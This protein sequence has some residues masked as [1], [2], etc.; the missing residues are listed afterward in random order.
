LS[1]G[2]ETVL[3]LL[4]AVGALILYILAAPFVLTWKLT[5][6]VTLKIVDGILWFVRGWE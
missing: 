1:F 6:W 3:L 4:K 2:P 5:V